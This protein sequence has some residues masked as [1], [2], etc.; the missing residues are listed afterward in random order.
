MDRDE[1]V[2]TDKMR[3]EKVKETAGLRTCAIS[4]VVLYVCEVF[5]KALTSID[6]LR[7]PFARTEGTI[8]D[9]SKP[10][11]LWKAGGAKASAEEAIRTAP[12][13][14]AHVVLK[15]HQR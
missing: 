11:V 12:A 10:G 1:E 7:P 5:T 14:Y 6:S 3:G 13:A 2:D 8:V 4:S 9:R 15:T